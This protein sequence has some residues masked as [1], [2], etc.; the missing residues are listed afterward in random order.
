MEREKSH[1]HQRHDID[2]TLVTTAIVGGGV[3]FFKPAYDR[4][5]A[6]FQITFKQ[7]ISSV[8]MKVRNN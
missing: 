8:G 6:I 4:T 7:I 5:R 2:N 1:H 3:L